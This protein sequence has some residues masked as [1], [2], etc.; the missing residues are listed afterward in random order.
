MRLSC[1][2]SLVGFN[3]PAC[4]LNLNSS[5][6]PTRIQFHSKWQQNFQVNS[7]KE[8]LSKQDRVVFW[9]LKI[10]CEPNAE[11][12]ARTQARAAVAGARCISIQMCAHS[13]SIPEFSASLKAPISGFTRLKWLEW[14][15]K[16]S[17]VCSCNRLLDC[18]QSYQA[19]C[20]F[21]RMLLL[22]SEAIC[23]STKI[24]TIKEYWHHENNN[25]NN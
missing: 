25:N 13:F 5:W 4:H 20:V 1:L 11:L 3:Y 16:L 8:K 17:N 23:S 10:V 22:C 24:G 7:R 21:V 15:T 14:A 12:I 18:R 6:V 2:S 19:I 9:L